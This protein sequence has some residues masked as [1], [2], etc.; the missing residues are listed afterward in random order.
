MGR[1]G[2]VPAVPKMLFAGQGGA[3]QCLQNRTE[4]RIQLAPPSSPVRTDHHSL[5]RQP[6]FWQRRAELSDESQGDC[7]MHESANVPIGHNQPCIP[8]KEVTMAPLPVSVIIGGK[9]YNGTY[10]V[11]NRMV[12]V[13]Y[14]LRQA[15]NEID[16]GA[17]A[18]ARALLRQLVQLKSQS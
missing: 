10:S 2:S 13:F 9:T 12:T 16:V 17:F 11:H 5:V 6:C 8:D 7:R 18:T 4:L 3:Q 15:T 14:G 1:R